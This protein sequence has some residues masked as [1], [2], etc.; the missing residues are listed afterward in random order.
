MTT[1]VRTRDGV[2]SARD[3]LSYSRRLSRDGGDDS[4][5]AG[6]SFTNSRD[7]GWVRLS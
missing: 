4:M 7:A 3:I 2:D 1:L 5:R 6:E